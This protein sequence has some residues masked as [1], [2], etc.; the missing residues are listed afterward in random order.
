VFGLARDHITYQPGDDNYF[1]REIDL[2]DLSTITD[3]LTAI[4]NEVDKAGLKLTAVVSGAGT[5]CFGT[6]EQFSPS[7]IRASVDL[8][9][10]SH[11]LVAR[12]VLPQMKRNRQGTLVFIGSQSALRGGAQGAVYCAAKFGLRGLAQSLRQDCAR[13][14]VR[15]SCVHPGAVMTPFFDDLGFAPGDEPGEALAADDVAAAVDA[16]LD[17]SPFAVVDELELSPIKRV[18]RKRRGGG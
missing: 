3:R 13:A 9:L 11:I 10:T 2:S 12:I 8:N 14:A 7:Q 5:G 17:A 6:V 18:F 16:V 1:P 15:V 4:V